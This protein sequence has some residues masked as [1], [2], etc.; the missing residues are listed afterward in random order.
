LIPIRNI[1][2]NRCTIV[3]EEHKWSK[4]FIYEQNI[5]TG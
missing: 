4:I 2:K 5:H 3:I 1:E